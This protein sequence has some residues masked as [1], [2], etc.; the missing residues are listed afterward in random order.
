MGSKYYDASSVIQVIGCSLKKPSLLDSDG[1]YFYNEDDF[2]S[3]FH[4]VVF[5]AINNLHSMGANNISVKDIENYLSTRENSR[6]IYAAGKGSEWLLNVTSEAD[7]ANFDYYYS[8]MKKMTLLRSY[9]SCGMDMSFIY[10]P[11]EIF[12]D[13]KKKRQEDYLDS[14]SLNE[15]ADI[16]DNRIFD[17][18]AQCVDNASDEIVL[19]GDG[20]FNLLESLESSPDVG[21]PLYDNKTNAVTRGAR[22]GKFYIRSAPTGVGILYNLPTIN[23]GIKR[24]N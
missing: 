14:L 21:V 17:V 16:I 18:R 10:D 7:L 2:V 19:A 13:A 11:D 20:I 15:I 9:E 23:R 4:K 22:L 8:R 12:D 1:Q 3:D 24:E 5:G 6:Q